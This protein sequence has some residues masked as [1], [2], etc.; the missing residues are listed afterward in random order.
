MIVRD[1][2]TLNL[3]S[4]HSELKSHGES[5]SLTDD[6][7]SS[8]SLPAPYCDVYEVPANGLL[9]GKGSESTAAYIRSGLDPTAY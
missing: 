7:P 9:A 3:V 8:C 1:A 5:L 2:G 6:A 4:K